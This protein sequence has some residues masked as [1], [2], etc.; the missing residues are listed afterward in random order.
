MCCLF[1]QQNGEILFVDLLKRGVVHEVQL[2]AN[3][4]SFD[5]VGDDQQMTTHLLVNLQLK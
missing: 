4:V 1:S 3:I 5:L 2:D